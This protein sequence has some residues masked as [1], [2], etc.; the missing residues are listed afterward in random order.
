MYFS[1]VRTGALP[2]LEVDGKQ[3]NQSM[4][5]ARYVAAEFSKY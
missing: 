2:M 1:D 5:I 4:A 3:L